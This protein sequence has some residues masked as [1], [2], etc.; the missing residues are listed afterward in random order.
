M[1][2]TVTVPT[3]LE[4]HTSLERLLSSL[5]AQSNSDF[6]CILIVPPGMKAKAFREATVYPL[7]L[8]VLEQETRGYDAAMNVAFRNAGDVNINVDDDAIAPKELIASHVRLVKEEGFGYV[9]GMV[10]GRLPPL[11]GRAWWIYAV[12][13]TLP[14]ERPLFGL[15][16][17]VI[18]FGASGFLQVFWRNLAKTLQRTFGSLAQQG[19]NTSWSG[20]LLRRFALP[21]VTARGILN[22]SYASLEVMRQGGRAVLSR[23]VNVLHEEHSS[24]SRTHDVN[25][26]KSVLTDAL[27]SPKVL[28]L[29]GYRVDMRAF[30]R[31]ERVMRRISGL[32][33]Y[34]DWF[35][36]ALDLTRASLL[37]CWNASETRQRNLEYQTAQTLK[38]S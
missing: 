21:C 5:Q 1:Q 24:L 8:E 17:A 13:S 19:V 11:V 12:C 9:G 14:W 4:R 28:E 37:E 35:R 15:T 18:D 31:Q 32:T 3:T 33:P 25:S 34:Q 36:G 29:L 27:L 23:A 22:E 38:R 26:M 2:V 16:D 6:R 20:P 30:Y 7:D 10:N